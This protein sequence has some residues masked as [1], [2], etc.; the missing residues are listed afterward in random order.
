M[1]PLI[2]IGEYLFSAC[3]IS[4]FAI[5]PSSVFTAGVMC[6]VCWEGFNAAMG[7]SLLSL[8]DP[9]LEIWF[10]VPLYVLLHSIDDGL[11]FVLIDY[12]AGSSRW[13]FV[14]LGVLQECCVELIFNARF[15]QYH[16][17]WYNPTSMFV[18]IM[19]WVIFSIAMSILFCN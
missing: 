16:E 3:V 2:A 6:G 12:F 11:I 17:T 7:P 5:F 8:V 19:E 9:K 10:P 13:K 15:W 1:I 4:Y 14:L 18:P